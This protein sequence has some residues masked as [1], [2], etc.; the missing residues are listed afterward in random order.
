MWEAFQLCH[1]EGKIKHIGVSNFARK[2][3]EALV[4]DPRLVPA[5]RLG[6][7]YRDILHNGSYFLGLNFL[8]H[9]CKW[10]LIMSIFFRQSHRS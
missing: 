3:I 6:P 10:S 1:K 8:G 2:H 4:K 9:K 5:G 7:G